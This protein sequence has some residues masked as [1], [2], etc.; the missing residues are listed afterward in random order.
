MA[1]GVLTGSTGANDSK[2]PTSFTGI[3]AIDGEE[4]PI[5]R[6]NYITRTL[7]VPAGEHGIRFTYL[8]ASYT[9]GIL[10][11]RISSVGLLLTLAAAVVFSCVRML[12]RK[13]DTGKQL[14]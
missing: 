2:N 12:R 5:L 7:L 9:T 10:V 6:S 8:P 11:S 14:P 13:K 4:V 1:K 3:L